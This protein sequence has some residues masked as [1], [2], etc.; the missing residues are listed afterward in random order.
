MKLGRRLRYYYLRFIRLRGE[1]RELALGFSFGVFS[2]LLPTIPFHTVTAVFLAMLFKGSKITAALGTWVS[3]PLNWVFLYW[4]NYKL[5]AWLLGLEPQQP[6]LVAV[7]EAVRSGARPTAV[8]G[9]ILAAGGNIVAA[10]LVGGLV[11]GVAAAVPAYYGSLPVFRKIAGY[12]RLRRE[13]RG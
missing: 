2:G 13:A 10:F 8:L 3:N 11:M 7:M 9:Q 1:P 4:C 12:R 6:R 5:G